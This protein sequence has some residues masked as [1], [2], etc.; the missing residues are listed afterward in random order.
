M[1]D[2]IQDYGAP[3]IRL[4]NITPV[5]SF[6]SVKPIPNPIPTNAASR[7][8]NGVNGAQTFDDRSDLLKDTENTFYGGGNAPP[9]PTPTPTPTTQFL[10]EIKSSPYRVSQRDLEMYG[11]GSDYGFTTY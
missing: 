10:P 2:P 8:A 4:R 5:P 1:A 9:T 6:N 11:A 3:F 7:I